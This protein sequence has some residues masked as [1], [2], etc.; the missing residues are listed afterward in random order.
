[1]PQFYLKVKNLV[2]TCLGLA[3]LYARTCND[4]TMRMQA[5]RKYK[6]AAQKKEELRTENTLS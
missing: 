6:I 1:M 4:H 2:A 5:V 3:F